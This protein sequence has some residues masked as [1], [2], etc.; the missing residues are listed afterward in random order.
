MVHTL[1]FVPRRSVK[2]GTVSTDIH[3]SASHP[4]EL[5]AVQSSTLE[6]LE[7]NRQILSVSTAI[8]WYWWP[9]VSCL[10]IVKPASPDACLLTEAVSPSQESTTKCR[11]IAIKLLGGNYFRAD[12]HADGQTF[13]SLRYRTVALFA[14]GCTMHTYLEQIKS[15]PG[16]S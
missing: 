4:S 6:H 5:A 13:R 14:S 9:F 2:I 15:R 10:N 1:S 8:D 12:R 16:S 11:L 3:W 7:S